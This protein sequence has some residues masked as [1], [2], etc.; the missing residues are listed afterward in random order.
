MALNQRRQEILNLIR[1]DGQAKVQKLAKIFKVSEVTIRQDLMELEELGFVQREYGGAYL[2]DV[3]NFASTG[4]LINENVRSEE[5]KELAL[6]ALQFIKD[7]DTIILDSGS[8]TTELAKLMNGFKDL[9]VITNALNIALILSARNP[10]INLLV[11]GGEFKAPTLSLTGDMAAGSFK[12]IH[13]SKCFLATAGITPDMQLTYPSLSDL[14]VK[15]AMIRAADKVYLLADSSK[16]GTSS[17]ASLGRL[18]LIDTLI[19][20]SKIT[21]AQLEAIRELKVEVI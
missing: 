6:K 16:I 9:N 11:S 10:G 2:K 17:F 13:V 3:G 7:G 15:S 21:P 18:S 20:D 1:E 12:G 5:K 19:T 4:T 8:T 14:P